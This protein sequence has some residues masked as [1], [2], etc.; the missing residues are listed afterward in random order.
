MNRLNQGLMCS[1]AI[2]IVDRQ[3]C[4]LFLVLAASLGV[5]GCAPP[6]VKEAPPQILPGTIAK[7][8]EL[9]IEPVEA[10][11]EP[12]DVSIRA[13]DPDAEAGEKLLGPPRVLAGDQRDLLQDFDGPKRDVVQVSDWRRDDE[14]SSHRHDGDPL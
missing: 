2:S 4:F 7:A 1:Q 8:A 12:L 3:R 11:D 9:L 5:L 14:Q 10:E 13:L 6:S